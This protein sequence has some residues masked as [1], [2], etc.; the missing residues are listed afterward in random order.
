M[1]IQT[2]EEV[3]SYIAG[4]KAAVLERPNAFKQSGLCPTCNEQRYV[5]SEDRDFGGDPCSFTI[6]SYAFCSNLKCS[7]YEYN[8]SSGRD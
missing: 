2:D 4:C 3:K 7:W 6:C 5:D 8:E 1:N